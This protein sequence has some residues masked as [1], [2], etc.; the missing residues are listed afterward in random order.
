MKT[1][2][3]RGIVFLMLIAVFSCNNNPS[4]QAAKVP[5]RVVYRGLYSYGPEVKSFK[6]CKTGQEFWAADSSAKLEL[7]YSQLHFE[8]PYEPVY[9]EVEGRKI[10][11]GKDGAASEFDSTLVV[12]KVV[13]LTKD[14][15]GDMC[16]T[17]PKAEST[18]PATK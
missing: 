15:P 17:E 2:L 10:K 9:V 14:I 11:S 4:K 13:K 5:E 7:G 8:K 16:N 6:D 1:I 3:N 18:K 12:T